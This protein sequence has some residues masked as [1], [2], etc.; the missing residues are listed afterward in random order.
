MHYYSLCYNIHPQNEV[1]FVLG[2]TMMEASEDSSISDQADPQDLQKI[3]HAEHPSNDEPANN[4][5]ET[6]LNATLDPEIEEVMNN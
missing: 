4:K 2:L 1:L 3:S 5:C 6:P